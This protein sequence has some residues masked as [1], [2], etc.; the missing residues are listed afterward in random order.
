MKLISVQIQ[1]YRSI[2]DTET[3]KIADT[4]CIVGKNE[5]EKTAIL[6]TLEILNSATNMAGRPSLPRGRKDKMCRE[7][8]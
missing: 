4:T 3:F 2:N 8:L 7:A 1:N 5:A 6:Q